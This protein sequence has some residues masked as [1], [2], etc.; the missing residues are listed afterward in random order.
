MGLD[1]RCMLGFS[2]RQSNAFSARLEEHSARLER[3]FRIAFL[4]MMEGMNALHDAVD[5]AMGPDS[6][7]ADETLAAGLAKL[8]DAND[9]LSALGETFV[10]IRTELFEQAD[11][12]PSDP[13]VARERYF[14]SIDYESAYRE[15]IA[16]GAALPQHVYWSELTA[17]LR[18]GGAR[19]GLRLL[20]RHLRELQSDLRSFVGEVQVKRRLTG[21]ALAEALHDASRPVA[22]VVMGFTRLL[23]TMTYFGVLC[24]RASQAHEQATG[25]VAALAAG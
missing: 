5:G 24:E 8:A 3:S 7:A 10:R 25:R 20:D 1:I 6:T 2:V 4:R 18:D 19:A 13:L 14:G 15:L 22:T 17:R 16:Y 9:Q 12:D 23:T 21:F 11:L